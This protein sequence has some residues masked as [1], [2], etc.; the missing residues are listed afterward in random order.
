MRI[1]VVNLESGDGRSTCTVNLACELAGLG[2]L[3]TDRWQGKYRVVLVDADVNG[4]A[5][6]YSSAGHLPVSSE[7]LPIENWRDMEGWIQRVLAI[8]VDFVVVDAPPKVD[9]ITK[10]IMGICDLVVIPWRSADDVDLV[11]AAEI[12]ELIRLVRSSRPDGG[13]ECLIVPTYV[14]ATSTAGKD[15]GTVLSKLGEEVAPPI[16]QRAAFVDAFVAGRWIGDF[17]YN[18]AAHKEFKALASAVRQ[19]GKSVS[20]GRTNH[21]PPIHAQARAVEEIH[22]APEETHE[23]AEL[24]ASAE[25]GSAETD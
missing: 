2:H 20:G 7:R 10:A 6:Q 15:I 8:Q 4:A 17:A 23:A 24:S 13:P 25:G 19:L 5:T 21:V 22:E 14:D 12:V 18:S 16:H 11:A 3:C 1:T 9:V